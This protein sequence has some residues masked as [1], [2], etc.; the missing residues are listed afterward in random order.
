MQIVCHAFPAWDGN[1]LKSTVE[2][3]K[4]MAER[5]HQVLYVDY[6]Y[7]WKDFFTQPPATRKRMLGLQARIRC[8]PVTGTGTLQVLTLPPVFPSNFLKHP[9]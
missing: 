8:I 7:T 6:A 9:V 2:L 1:Y 4:R 3:M 5:G